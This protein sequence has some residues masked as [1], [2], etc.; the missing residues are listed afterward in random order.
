MVAGLRDAIEAGVLPG[1]RIIFGGWQIWGNGGLSSETGHCPDGIEGIKRAV[2]LLDGLGAN[3]LKHRMFS[4]MPHFVNIIQEAHSYGWP[5]SGHIAAP[6]PL[7]AAGTD[8]MEHLS[9]SGKRTD[10]VL[11]DDMVQLFRASDMWVIPTIV[12]YSS[13]GRFAEDPSCLNWST[14]SP[15][16]SPF[17]RWWGLR[18]SPQH[19]EGYYIFARDAR[20]GTIKLHQAGVT[21]GAGSD[22]PSAPWALHWELE[23]MVAAGMTP[24]EALCAATS[25]AASILCADAEIGS[26][27]VGKR[28]DLVILNADPLEDI[29]NTRNIWSVIKNGIQVDRDSLLA[30]GAQWK[31]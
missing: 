31:N 19:V 10:K 25:V 24:I 13:V 30:L 28:A 18:F 9:V 12:A 3:Y 17:M 29:S 22:T 11:Y 21:I 14:E 15:F 6:L 4:N 5:T 8:G 2:S 20:E 27:V 7:V 26:I 1:P 16:A 23:E